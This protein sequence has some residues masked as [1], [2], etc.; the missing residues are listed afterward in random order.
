MSHT[1]KARQREF[2]ELTMRMVLDYLPDVT[3]EDY[4]KCEELAD[5]I[6][7]NARL[8]NMEALESFLDIVVRYL[9]GGNNNAD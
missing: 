3:P 9:D 8:D 4:A 6:L 5:R 2:T 7:R 1:T